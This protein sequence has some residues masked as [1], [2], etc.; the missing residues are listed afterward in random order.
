GDR[1]TVYIVAVG[2]VVLV[3]VAIEHHHRQTDSDNDLTAI[4]DGGHS[5]LLVDGLLTES[6][7]EAAI[8]SEKQ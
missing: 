3:A 6:T 7:L 1:S 4:E 8:E 2:V 5:V